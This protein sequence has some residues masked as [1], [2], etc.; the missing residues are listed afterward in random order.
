MSYAQINQ[1]DCRVRPPAPWFRTGLLGILVPT[2]LMNPQTPQRGNVLHGQRPSSLASSP[3][4]T[5]KSCHSGGH[6]E[7]NKLDMPAQLYD[8]PIGSPRTLASKYLQLPT[9]SLQLAQ[10][11][12]VA[13]VL[14]EPLAFSS[15]PPPGKKAGRSPPLN[16]APE[17]KEP[18]WRRPKPTQSSLEAMRLCWPSWNQVR[19]LP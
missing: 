15:G 17:R 7:K 13:C 10:F 8:D 16:S 4:E 12:A 19:L 18:Q 9:G 5:P 2:I 1:T 14:L 3:G 6:N 11:G